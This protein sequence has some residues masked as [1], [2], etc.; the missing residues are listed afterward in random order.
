M[1]S[2][3][4]GFTYNLTYYIALCIR[5]IDIALDMYRDSENCVK[6]CVQGLSAFDGR[7]FYVKRLM[8]AVFGQEFSSG[9]GVGAAL[10]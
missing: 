1:Q 8:T 4:A 10:T 7:L 6:D 9:H 5:F 2:A 3:N